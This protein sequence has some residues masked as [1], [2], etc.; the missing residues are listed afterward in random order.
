MLSSIKPDVVFKELAPI[1]NPSSEI[2]VLPP[3]PGAGTTPPIVS[4]PLVSFHKKC[5]VVSYP[6][7]DEPL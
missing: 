5:V 3:I 2:P 4:K 1:V 6:A 7:A